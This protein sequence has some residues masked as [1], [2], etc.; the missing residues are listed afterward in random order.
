LYTLSAISLCKRLAIRRAE[1]GCAEEGQGYLRQRIRSASLN[2]RL[3][4]PPQILGAVS[5]GIPVRSSGGFPIWPQI[6]SST[7]SPSILS[8]SSSSKFLR[9]RHLVYLQIAINRYTERSGLSQW[10]VSTSAIRH[11]PAREPSTFGPSSCPPSSS[12]L[13]ITHV[14]GFRN[15]SRSRCWPGPW[16]GTITT[17]RT[18]ST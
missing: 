1:K 11:L 5:L 3:P 18:A 17:A 4:W 8:S 9:S 13:Y 12:L 15:L 16:A 7:P 6:R 14:P 10:M 2:V